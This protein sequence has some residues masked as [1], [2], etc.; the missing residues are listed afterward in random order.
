MNKY[1]QSFV[2]ILVIIAFTVILKLNN[3]PMIIIVSCSVII[4]PIMSE[5]GYSPAAFLRGN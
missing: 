1:Q 5:L 3:V 4:G 2:G